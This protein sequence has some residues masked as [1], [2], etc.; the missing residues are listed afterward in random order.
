MKKLKKEHLSFLFDRL[1]K[2]HRVIGPKIESGVIVLGEI[3]IHDIPAGFED[4]QKAGSYRLL[5]GE[6]SE[7]FS[8][9]PGPD[10]FKRFLHP[11]VSE[12]FT[13][14]S[15]RT[16]MTITTPGQEEKPPAFIGVRAC[17]IAA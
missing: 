13:F 8:F 16:G 11:P 1:N 4:H 12:M 9:S 7:T 10:S 5:K 3:D 6:R 15:S 17:D 2:S 14:K